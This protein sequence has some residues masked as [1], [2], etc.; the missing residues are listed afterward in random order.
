MLSTDR[1]FFTIGVLLTVASF[2]IWFT[3]RPPPAGAG[4]GGH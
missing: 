2:S 4:A 1:I 3:K